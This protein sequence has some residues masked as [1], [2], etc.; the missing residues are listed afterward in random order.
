[1]DKLGDLADSFVPRRVDV[2][3]FGIGIEQ[4]VEQGAGGEDRLPFG[5]IL[6]LQKIG[7]KGENTS[8]EEE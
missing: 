1:V 7:D 5:V 6:V 3:L 8:L 4:R 2:V